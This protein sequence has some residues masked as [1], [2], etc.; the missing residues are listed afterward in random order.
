VAKGLPHKRTIAAA[1]VAVQVE[2]SQNHFD[3][4]HRGD[5]RLPAHDRLLLE[6]DT[7][8]SLLCGGERRV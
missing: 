6:P 7:L 1:P 2:V 8:I 3:I 5:N 4:D